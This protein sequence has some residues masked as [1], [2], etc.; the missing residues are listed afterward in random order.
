MAYQ[1]DRRTWVLALLGT[2]ALGAVGVA[3]AGSPPLEL[4]VVDRA[5][6]AAFDLHAWRGRRYVVGE[7]GREFELR[8][9]NRT[10]ERLLAVPSVDGINVLD[11]STASVG[12]AGYV[13]GPW[14]SI[15]IEGWRKSLDDVAAFYFTALSDSYAAR[16]GR[17]GNAGVIGVAVFR[18]RRRYQETWL[19][20]RAVNAPSPAGDADA[21]AEARAEAPAPASSAA[22][23]VAKSGAAAPQRRERLGTGHGRRLESRVEQVE[24]ERASATPDTIRQIYYDSEANLVAQ[25]VLRRA[26]VAQ[27]RPEPFPAGFVPDP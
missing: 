23:S 4:Q 6:G 16:T 17:P 3:R 15:A 5:S 25:G 7:P 24:F 8:L 2:A 14:Q 10:G 12:G 11:G 9:R 1:F 20:D 21:A 22:E 18:E 13:L 26:D 19:S 27:R